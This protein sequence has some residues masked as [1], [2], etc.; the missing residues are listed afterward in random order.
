MS[1]LTVGRPAGLVVTPVLAA[2]LP[3]KAH[4]VHQC[5][6]EEHWRG[7]GDRYGTVQRDHL[8]GVPLLDGPACGVDDQD[9][10]VDG[11]GREGQGG[12]A[13]GGA[14][15]DGNELAEGCAE[16]PDFRERRDG[17]DGAGDHGDDD[18]GAGE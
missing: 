18:V 16:E 9:E 12:E 13:E 3:A 8:Q 17:G 14:L 15:D 4:I 10:A 1:P 2:E 11:Y 5:L 6:L 7:D